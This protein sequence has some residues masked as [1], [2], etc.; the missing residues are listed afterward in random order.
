[1]AKRENAATKR[2]T[3]AWLIR[4][5]AMKIVAKKK[6]DCGGTLD[7]DMHRM[8]EVTIQSPELCYFW[9]L[10]ERIWKAILESQARKIWKLYLIIDDVI[11]SGPWKG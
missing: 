2:A 10:F 6:A 7:C 4:C 8:I 11:D 3:V 5:C 1:M 9:R